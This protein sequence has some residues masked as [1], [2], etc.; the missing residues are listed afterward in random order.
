MCISREIYTQLH[1]MNVDGAIGQIYRRRWRQDF[2]PNLHT[3]S[4]ASAIGLHR[5]PGI[6]STNPPTNTVKIIYTTRR[7]AAGVMGGVTTMRR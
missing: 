7:D 3:I 4:T 1:H 2:T 5:P 6:V